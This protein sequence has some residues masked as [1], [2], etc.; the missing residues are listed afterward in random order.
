MFQTSANYEY[1]CEKEMK[2]H[3]LVDQSGKPIVNP[4]S[5]WTGNPNEQPTGE[6][7][8][9]GMVFRILQSCQKLILELKKV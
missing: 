1:K 7:A 3:N 5:E 9:T 4:T 2:T 8:D 6:A